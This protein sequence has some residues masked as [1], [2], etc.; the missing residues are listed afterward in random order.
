MHLLAIAFMIITALFVLVLLLVK[1]RLAR[2]NDE[3]EEK[4]DK[5]KLQKRTA[6]GRGYDGLSFRS[7]LQVPPKEDDDDY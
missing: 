7:P 3:R 6:Y 4:R 2:W 1:G 5:R